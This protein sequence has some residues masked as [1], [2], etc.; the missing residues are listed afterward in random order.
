MRRGEARRGKDDQRSMWESG[1]CGGVEVW[2]GDF[3]KSK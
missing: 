2:R 1:K 3:Q